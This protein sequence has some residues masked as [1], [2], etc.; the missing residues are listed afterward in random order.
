M[1]A[2]GEAAADSA[3]VVRDRVVELPVVVRG[4]P[5]VVRLRSADP[6]VVVPQ[7]HGLRCHPLLVP[8][9]EVPR[10]QA[11]AE[12]TSLREIAPRSSREHDQTFQR[13]REEPHDQRR[14]LVP[15]QGRLRE[16]DQAPGLEIVL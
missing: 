8:I 6:A 3:V 16:L 15:D 12:A 9:L 4:R 7:R 13:V 2:V 11:S 5:W 1:A 14:Y 10:S